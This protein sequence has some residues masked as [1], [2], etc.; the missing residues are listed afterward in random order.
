MRLTD[1]CASKRAFD[2]VCSS[3]LLKAKLKLI[4]R[5]QASRRKQ[6]AQSIM[7]FFRMIAY[8]SHCNF[9]DFP[10]FAKKNL[11]CAEI[12]KLPPFAPHSFNVCQHHSH[13]DFN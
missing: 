2:G 13:I 10:P 6:H 11:L 7:D 3:P 5:E 12:V 8:H 4:K 9:P 1:M